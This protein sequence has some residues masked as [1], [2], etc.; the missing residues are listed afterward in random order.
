M[1]PRE[2]PPGAVQQC[3]ATSTRS[4][5]VIMVLKSPIGDLP[6]QAFSEPGVAVLRPGKSQGGRYGHIQSLERG[7]F[8]IQDIDSWRRNDRALFGLISGRE[9]LWLDGRHATDFTAST[10][11]NLF[12]YEFTDGTQSLAN[13]R[14]NRSVPGNI[15]GYGKWDYNDD[16]IQDTLMLP[17][18]GVSGCA[19]LWSDTSAGGFSNRQNG[20]V[21]NFYLGVGPFSL[22]G[23]RHDRVS[24]VLR[25]RSSTP[26]R[27]TM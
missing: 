3:G 6:E 4:I 16:G 18:C 19:K 14:Y 27:S 17:D 23:R 26:W 7:G 24:L 8:G 10:I 2:Q 12:R 1:Y 21:F 20:E 25:R 5:H 22:R 13:I 11:W 15:P 9:D